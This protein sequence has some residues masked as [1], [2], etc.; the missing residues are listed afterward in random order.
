MI[1]VYVLECVEEL[2]NEIRD[3]HLIRHLKVSPLYELYQVQ[4]LFPPTLYVQ[5]LLCPYNLISEL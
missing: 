1:R 2:D 5:Q 3:D 4:H